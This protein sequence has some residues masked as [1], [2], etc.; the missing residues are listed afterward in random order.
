M[1]P[2]VSRFLRNNIVTD[3][4]TIHDVAQLSAH[5]Y[6]IVVERAPVPTIHVIALPDDIKGGQY[7]QLRSIQSVP[8]RALSHWYDRYY[9]AKHFCKVHMRFSS[10]CELGNIQHAVEFGSK[11]YDEHKIV[12]HDSVW[13]YYKNIGFDYKNKS[14]KHLEEVFIIF[15]K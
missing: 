5:D 10:T 12:V 2:I 8:K 7:W 11:M 3:I 13:Q 9:N 4:K 6:Y 1:F 15:D 14:V